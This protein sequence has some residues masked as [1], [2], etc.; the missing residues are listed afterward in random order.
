[1]K[2]EKTIRTANN[3]YLVYIYADQN[4]ENQYIEDVTVAIKEFNGHHLT[5]IYKASQSKCD[6]DKYVKTI[7]STIT[8]FNN[9]EALTRLFDWDGNID[10]YESK[11]IG[12]DSMGRPVYEK[13]LKNN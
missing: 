9:D 5:Y 4:E 8:Q 1:M 2:F 6:P 12:I 7:K 3:D 13:V 10:L 11:T